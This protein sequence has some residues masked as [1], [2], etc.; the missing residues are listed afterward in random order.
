MKCKNCGAEIGKANFCEFCGSQILAD[1]KK[2]QEYLNKKGCPNCNSNNINYHRE[3]Q[4]EVKGKNSKHIIHRTVGVCKDC[5][6]TW[7]ADYHGNKSNNSDK[8]IWLWVLGWIFIFP[9]PLT[10][11]LLSKKDM[12]KVLKYSIIAVAWIFFLIFYIS[13]MNSGDDATTTTTGIAQSNSI[14]DVSESPLKTAKNSFTVINGVAGE[15]GKKRKI[16]TGTEFEREVIEYHIPVG[17]YKVLNKD[18]K[19]TVQISIYSNEW[20]KNEQ[21][22]E[23]PAKVIG[24]PI[25]ISPN[26]EGTIKVLENTYVKLPDGK[27]ELL[28][29]KID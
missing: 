24:K 5:G 16:N 20:V 29:T 27:G 15:Y 8:K 4:G 1:M 23:E 7:Y 26:G 9:V 18:F 11:I 2:E 22:I 13:G 14:G 28:F 19:A 21:G 6:F 25:R 10:I 3:N 12:N 17:E